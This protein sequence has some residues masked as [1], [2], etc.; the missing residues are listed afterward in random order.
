MACVTWLWKS[1]GKEQVEHR[2]TKGLIRVS[3]FFLQILICY[4][5]HVWSHYSFLQFHRQSWP[6]PTSFSQL[7]TKK[8]SVS[9]LW[10]SFKRCIYKAP[11]EF[12]S[13]CNK[14]HLS[15]QKTPTFLSHLSG[16]IWS[17]SLRG[18]SLPFIFSF[19]SKSVL[20][21]HSLLMKWPVKSSF[22]IFWI[23]MKV[24][25]LQHA[26]FWLSTK[27]SRA[28]PPDRQIESPFK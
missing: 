1:D 23:G 28:N 14:Y 13:Y 16:L 8:R 19:I 26:L 22:P 5:E 15:L 25:G 18:K 3:Q 4:T 17:L 21:T 9:T 2:I 11:Y 27:T 10:I 20:F 12:F 24:T 7:F 6:C